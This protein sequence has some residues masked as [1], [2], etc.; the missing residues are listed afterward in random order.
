MCFMGLT[1]QQ[2]TCGGSQVVQASGARG[3]LGNGPA[4][5]RERE[6]MGVGVGGTRIEV[7]QMCGVE[8]VESCGEFS[9]CLEGDCNGF[10]SPQEGVCI[11]AWPVGCAPEGAQ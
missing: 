6:V 11:R 8:N 9:A 2:L 4:A 7:W 1:S 5:P 3:A 10:D